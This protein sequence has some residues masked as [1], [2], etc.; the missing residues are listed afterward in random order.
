M[1]WALSPVFPLSFLLVKY[2][3]NIAGLIFKS[4]TQD[5]RNFVFEKTEIGR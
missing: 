5:I 3:S 4:G 1:G 2:S